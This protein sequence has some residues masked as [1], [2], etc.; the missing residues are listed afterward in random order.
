MKKTIL[1]L[2]TLLTCESVEAQTLLNRQWTSFHNGALS[3]HDYG[4]AIIAGANGLVYV[5]GRSFEN[6]VTGS[7]VTVC[8]SSG[9]TML[10]TDFYKGPIVTAINEGRDICLDPFGNVFVTGTVA[11][12]DGDFAILKF[13]GAGRNFQECG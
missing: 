9:G 10:W 2:C 12:N 11:F 4:K 1:I 13:N 8:Y 5:T 3:N 6:N 7:L